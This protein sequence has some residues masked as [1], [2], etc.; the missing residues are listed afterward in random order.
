[1]RRALEVATIP[2]GHAKAPLAPAMPA[3]HFELQIVDQ[4]IGR[5]AVAGLEIPVGK[6]RAATARA[7][8]DDVR[9]RLQI[10]KS[11][12]ARIIH[13]LRT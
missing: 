8:D 6:F 12:E 9:A 3:P 1:M 10:Q 13:N 4:G 2:H 5:D 11:H 7:S